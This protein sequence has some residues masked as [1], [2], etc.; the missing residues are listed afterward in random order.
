MNIVKNK[1]Q[2]A[3]VVVGYNR[4]DSLKR[5]LSSLEES[6]FDADPIPLIIS[7]D[8]SGNKVLYDFVNA[9]KW[10]YGPCYININEQR[11]GLKQHILQCGNLTKYFKA[12]V[13]FEDDIVVSPYFYKY[14]KN[15]VLNYVEDKKIAEISLY[16]NEVNGF[17]QLPFEPRFNGADVFLM[18][19]VSTWGECWTEDMWNDF[20]EWYNNHDESYIN[21]VRMP[22]KIKKWTRAWSKYYYAYIVDTGKY[23]LFPYIS[24]TTNYSEAGEHDEIGTSS[25]Q[26]N[27]LY[28]DLVYTMRDSSKLERYDVFCNNEILYKALG[29]DQDQLELDLYGYGEFDKS[30]RY[31]LSTKILPYKVIKSFSL[32]LRPIEQ[33]VISNIVGRGIFL[34]D[35]E[36]FVKVKEKEN[37]FLT[38]YFIRGIRT[39]LVVGYVS[40]II[41]STIRRRLKI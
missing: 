12:I 8:A 34:Y 1:S 29:F 41:K 24:L 7:I 32:C 18:Q 19:D 5:L 11:L 21:K 25:L 31:L 22:E 9:Y 23:V 2:I 35:K 33:N 14:V 20:I 36:V 6:K 13:L 39:S 16:R 40:N 3:I 26:T 10:N 30:K 4:L 15:A 38:Y 27:M 17:V 28:G 37:L